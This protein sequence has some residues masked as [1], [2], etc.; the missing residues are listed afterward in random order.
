MPMFRSLGADAPLMLGACALAGLAAGLVIYSLA[1][2]VGLRAMTAGP[3]QVQLDARMLRQRAASVTPTLR[4]AI[5]LMPFFLPLAR[6]L[7][8]PSVRKMLSERYARAGW[9]GG[10]ATDELLAL[11][12]MVGLLLAAPLVLALAVIEPTLAPLGILGI[13]AGPG[14]CS[15]S[16]D[17][18]G[19]WRER[20][21]TKA[22]PFV[23]DLLVLTMRAGASL[24]QAI[25][26][27]ALDYAGHPV[28]VEFQAVLTDLDMG[29]TTA[30]G[31]E[32][33]AERVP[34]PAVETFVDDLTGAEELGRPVA[35][36]FER[37]AVRARE[38]RVQESLETAGQAKVT[39]LVPGMLVF[40]ASLL[41]L[42]AP[43]VVRYF[44]GGYTAG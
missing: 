27:V 20:E 11:S 22:M 24:Q 41:L 33:L 25:E 16:L 19:A 8:L 2:Q 37:Q 23:L 4:L 32:S 17:R 13:V 36:I 9:P 34:I 26:R 28:G 5:S 38:R 31:F 14:L 44:Y 6:A 12:L 18:R 42:F 7:R 43:F 40:M 21:I 35:D 30:E 3:G 1:A 15:S 29:V 39:V 10:L